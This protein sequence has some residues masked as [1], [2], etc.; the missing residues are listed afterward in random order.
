MAPSTKLE[1]TKLGEQ[2]RQVVG[3]AIFILLL[4]NFSFINLSCLNYSGLKLYPNESRLCRYFSHLRLLIVG[5]W[6]SA[7]GGGRAYLKREVP[8][9]YLAFLYRAKV[10][11]SDI[12]ATTNAC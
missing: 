7:V 11:F 9:Y 1:V 10:S 8:I 12:N 3:M 2:D 6:S 5:K 4:T